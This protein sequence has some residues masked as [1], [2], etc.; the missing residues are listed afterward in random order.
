MKLRQP[1]QRITTDSALHPFVTPF[2]IVGYEIPGLPANNTQL[3]RRAPDCFAIEHFDFTNIGYSRGEPECGL[4]FDGVLRFLANHHEVGLPQQ[5]SFSLR[6]AEL[7]EC[8]SMQV[9]D[10]N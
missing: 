7:F 2:F 4:R 10:L 3:G 9:P 1:F 6:S 8:L 5:R